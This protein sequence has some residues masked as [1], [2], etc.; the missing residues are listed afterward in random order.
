MQSP[1]DLAWFLFSFGLATLL[2]AAVLL[3]F[4]LRPDLAGHLRLKSE[5]EASVGCS[6]V[7]VVILVVAG[8][9]GIMA[10]GG[11]FR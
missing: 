8:A 4:V 3:L 1:S 7:G 2:C 6:V 9:I 5:N 11:V 10:L